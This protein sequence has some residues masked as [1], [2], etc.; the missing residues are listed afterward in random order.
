MKNIIYGIVMAVLGVL[1]VLVL[2]TINGKMTRQAELDDSLASAVE[3]ALD[4]CLNRKNYEIT[5]DKEF[6]AD[7]NQELLTQIENDADIEVQ[8][9]KVDKDKG[10]LGIR[11]KETFENP[12][13]KES[14][15]TYETSVYL[16]K[17]RMNNYYNIVFRD[18]NGDIISRNKIKDSNVITAPAMPDNFKCWVDEENNQEVIDLGKAVKDKVYVAAYL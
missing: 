1:I 18:S 11:V 9:T 15:Q 14:E 4:N 16:D 12:N 5:N 13:K 6:I 17:D 3:N 8:L 2:L 10:V 7:F